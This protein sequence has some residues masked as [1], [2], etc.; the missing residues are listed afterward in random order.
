[1]A[2]A[3]LQ[4]TFEIASVKEKN[5]VNNRVE[6]L[7]DKLVNLRGKLKSVEEVVPK[8]SIANGVSVASLAVNSTSSRQQQSQDRRREQT[9]QLYADYEQRLARRQKQLAVKAEELAGKLARIN[10]L[11]QQLKNR[12][13]DLAE[14]QINEGEVLSPSELGERF[15]SIDRQRLEFFEDDGE[16]EMLIAGNSAP[17]AGE[18]NNGRDAESFKYMLKKGWALALSLGMVVGIFAII[19]ALIIF[20]GWR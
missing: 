17:A 20:W 4:A 18:N 2:K 12:K 3:V 13:S 10:E 8:D 9:E 5:I 14:L 6:Y 15:R 19:A 11:A 16:I 7:S 1:M